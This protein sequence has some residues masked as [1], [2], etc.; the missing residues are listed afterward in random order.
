[1]RWTYALK[2]MFKEGIVMIGGSDA[3]VEPVSPILGMYAAT[4]RKTFPQE[5]L[6]ITEALS[7]YTINAAY[8]SFEEDT[9]GSI[10]K[11]KLADLVVL[12]EN[13]FQTPHEQLKQIKVVMTIVAG[14]IVYERRPE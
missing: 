13:P 4:A 6:T 5:R 14:K 10:E 9:K 7:L 3:P 11:G 12:S 1:A 8:A 2:S